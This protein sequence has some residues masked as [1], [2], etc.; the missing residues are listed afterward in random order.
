LKVKS[1]QLKPKVENQD[2]IRHNQR[3]K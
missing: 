3:S 1:S 2:W